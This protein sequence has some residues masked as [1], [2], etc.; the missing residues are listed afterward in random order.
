MSVL[1]LR[2][3]REMIEKADKGAQHYTG[4]DTGKDLQTSRS[5]MPGTCT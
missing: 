3:D 4:M 1:S 2:Q 5:V